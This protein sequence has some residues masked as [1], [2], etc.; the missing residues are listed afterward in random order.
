MKWSYLEK[1]YLQAPEFKKKLSVKAEKF[2]KLM[3]TLKN[4][5]H[6][7]QN[8]PVYYNLTLTPS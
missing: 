1:M 7:P 2:V 3:N 6:H 8:T 5:A 4:N